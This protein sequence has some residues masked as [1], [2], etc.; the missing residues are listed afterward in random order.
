VGSRSTHGRKR[1]IRRTGRHAAHSQARTVAITAGKAAP[2]VVVLGA[3]AAV[4]QIHDLVASATTSVS[5]GPPAATPLIPL[6]SV[7]NDAADNPATFRDA[8]YRPWP[9]PTATAGPGARRPHARGR[10]GNAAHPAVLSSGRHAAS[11]SPSPS[12]AGSASSGSSGSVPKC[13]A[14][15]GPLP[16]NYAAIVDF[17]TAHGYTGLAAAGIA[18]NMYQ[19]SG[20]NPESVGDGGGGLIGWTPLPSGYVTGNPAADLQTQLN[21]VLTFNQQWAQF[22][23]ALNAATSAAQAADIYVQDFERAGVPAASN[24]EA[25]AQA[26]AA[27]CGL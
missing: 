9:G 24:R 6:S 22:I 21:A 17:L 26:V 15:A 4:P 11:P 3:L 25:A 27:A 5:G 2:A 19:E 14:G 16:E 13:T 10:S 7:V 12:P 8:K 18:G 20:G 23:P 1:K